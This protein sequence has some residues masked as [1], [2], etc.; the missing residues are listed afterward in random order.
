MHLEVIEKVL[1]IAQAEGFIIGGVNFSP[2]KGPE[3]NIEYLL[4]AGKNIAPAA[5]D[6]KALVDLAHEQAGEK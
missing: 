6:I 2:I 5:I 1:G 4:W 3:G